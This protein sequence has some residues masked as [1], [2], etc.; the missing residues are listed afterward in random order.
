MDNQYKE[1]G[2]YKVRHD[3]TKEFVAFK[4]REEKLANEKRRAWIVEQVFE[5]LLSDFLVL[6]SGITS[7][8]SPRVP[9]I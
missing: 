7:R 5:F 8:R 9:Y 3:G 6:L 2:I 1:R 4:T